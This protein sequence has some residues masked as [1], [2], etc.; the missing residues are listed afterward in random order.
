MR[1]QSKDWSEPGAGQ[2]MEEFIEFVVIK[3]DMGELGKFRLFSQ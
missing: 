2:G 1:L 3:T